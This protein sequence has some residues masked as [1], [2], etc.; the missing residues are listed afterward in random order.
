[1]NEKTLQ[2]LTQLLREIHFLSRSSNVDTFHKDAFDKLK[3]FFPYTCGFWYEGR[4]HAEVLAL[5]FLHLHQFPAD[6]AA[7]FEQLKTNRK[8]IKIIAEHIKQPNQVLVYDVR[9]IGLEVFFKPFNITQL[10]SFYQRDS[11]LGLY[12]VVTLCC[13]DTERFVN[14]ERQLLEGAFIHLLDAKRECW[15]LHLH[16]VAKKSQVDCL[17]A[18]LFDQA[19]MVH[20]ASQSFI[21][22][23][24]Q[25]WPGWHGPLAPQPIRKIGEYTFSGKLIAIR[26][27]QHKGYFLAIARQRGLLDRLS[28]RE[29]EVAKQLARGANYKEIALNLAVAP[30]T[31]RN[32]IAR[33]HA[34]LHTNKAAQVSN[35]FSEGDG[36]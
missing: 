24:L 28:T 8:Y 32:H 20:F 18:A 13:C 26:F 27:T 12:Q 36:I 19:G 23:L 33:I 30:S 21:S 14:L 6:M 25:E 7:G 29:L 1:M 35:F 34:K 4:G 15:L 11:N 31:A 5:N 3:E 2:H 10:L 16:D 22:H 17:A 9:D